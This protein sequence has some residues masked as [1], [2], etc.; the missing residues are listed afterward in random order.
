MGVSFP[1]W[2]R[3]SDD[4]L[5]KGYEKLRRVLTENQPP[6]A[7]DGGELFFQIQSLEDGKTKEV[8]EWILT[9]L[10]ADVDIEKTNCTIGDSL[11]GG[12]IYGGRMLHGL[13]SS[14]DPLGFS[15]RAIIGDEFPQHKGGCF[16]LTQRF[17]H[18]WQQLLQTSA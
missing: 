1:Q 12:R 16:C 18:D 10:G 9:E 14:V 11:H 7:L 4:G 17:I 8:A 5:F 15:A 6:Y 2:T 13:I 3:W